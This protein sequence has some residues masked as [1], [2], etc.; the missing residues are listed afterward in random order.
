MTDK[1]HED[2]TPSNDDSTPHNKSNNSSES[3]ETKSEPTEDLPSE[4][5]PPVLLEDFKILKKIGGGGFG[6]VWLSKSN[7]THTYR[8]IKFFKDNKKGLIELEGL[9]E[10]AF[11]SKEHANILKI[12]YEGKKN[13]WFY[14]VTELADSVEFSPA[15]IDFVDKYKPKNLSEV[16]KNK[17]TSLKESINICRQILRGLK[18]LHDNNRIH[19]DIK[20]RNILYVNGVVKLGDIGLISIARENLPSYST[21]AYAPKGGV[22]DKSG[23]LFSLGKLLLQ[24]ATGLSPTYYPNFDI[25]LKGEQKEAYDEL[26][27][28][29]DQACNPFPSRRFKSCEDFEEALLNLDPEYLGTIGDYNLIENI[30]TGGSG[31]VY[32]AKKIN[33]EQPPVALKI[34]PHQELNRFQQECEALVRLNHPNVAKIYDSG[35]SDLGFPYIATEFIKSQKNGVSQNIIEYANH[36]SLSVDERLQLFIE[37]CK[38]IEHAHLNG[39]IHRD[40]KPENILISNLDEIVLP[41]IIDFGLAKPIGR[42]RTHTINHLAGTW[43]FMSPEQLDNKNIL[44][45]PQSDIY[46]LGCLLYV[47]LTDSPPI[48]KE[49]LNEVEFQNQVLNNTPPDLSHIISSQIDKSNSV[50]KMRSTTSQK[51]ISR[52]KSDLDGIAQLAVEKDK[53]IRYRNAADFY[54]VIESSLEEKPIPAP[55][56]L[57]IKTSFLRKFLRFFKRNKVKLITIGVTGI[58]ITALCLFAFN[59]YAYFK[60]ERRTIDLVQNSK[61]DIKEY[62]KI[63]AKQNNIYKEILIP[64]NTLALHKFDDAAIIQAKNEIENLKRQRVKYYWSI[65]SKLNQAIEIAPSSSFIDE[66]MTMLSEFNSYL[67]KLSEGGQNKQILNELYKTSISPPRTKGQIEIIGKVQLFITPRDAIVKIF[68]FE[69]N[70]M[71]LCLEPRELKNAIYSDKNLSPERKS[72]QL[73]EGSYLVTAAQTDYPKTSYPILINSKKEKVIRV[74]L[75]HKSRYPNS[76]EYVYVPKGPSYLGSDPESFEPLPPQVKMVNDFLI[77]KHEVTIEEYEQFINDPII[78]CLTDEAGMLTAQDPHVIKWLSEKGNPD[79]K[80]N[81]NIRIIP[82]NAFKRVNN[83]WKPVPGLRTYKKKGPI[84]DLSQFAAMEYIHWLNNREGNKFKYRLPTDYEWEKAARGEDSRYFPWGNHM[85]WSYCGN[86]RNMPL[87]PVLMEDGSTKVLHRPK[88]VGSWSVDQ[89]IYGLMDMAGSVEELCST[90]KGYN[91][92]YA[93]VKG[94]G[95]SI[96][97]EYYFRSANRNGMDPTGSAG[98]LGFR[99]VV[100]LIQE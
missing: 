77:K 93:V 64:Y 17:R 90:Y 48:V 10:L 53:N 21:P 22:Q 44:L 78:N 49:E 99:L 45:G 69:F 89:S 60:K 65:I 18:H 58:I 27:E 24:L 39:I 82:R 9:R 87:E 20:P 16:L 4:L 55:Y 12:Y 92:G 63:T 26:E 13:D 46:S 7:L 66:P 50:S 98:W 6:Q 41:K 15:L 3:E 8:A 52:L 51:L 47:L 80:E 36:N 81:L 96:V 59:G 56:D 68:K 85:I 32:L 71:T 100:D 84:Y 76:A 31:I 73:R 2:S 5:L 28:I 75:I 30:G 43:E 54:E 97:D 25:Q 40:I 1:E 42:Q 94:G 57:R 61:A 91:S 95:Y 34:F 38:G 67:F 33:S 86:N 62:K 74:N 19:R 83:L 37:V 79:E 23:D 70:P 11:L 14:Y 72:L 29:I 88:V 35:I